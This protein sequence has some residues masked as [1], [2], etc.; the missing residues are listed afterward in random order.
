MIVG[1]AGQ[2]VVACICGGV[3]G[4]VGIVGRGGF[5]HEGGGGG[6]HVGSGTIHGEGG[7]GP[8]GGGVSFACLLLAIPLPTTT[9]LPTCVSTSIRLWMCC[10]GINVGVLD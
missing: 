7:Y 9:L 4:S 3:G 5:A 1:R 8:M 2:L 6:I 10:C